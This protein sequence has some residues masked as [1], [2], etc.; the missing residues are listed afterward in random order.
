MTFTT[1]KTKIFAHRGFPVK[2]PEN[3]LPSFKLALESGADGIELDVILTK[4]KQPVVVHDFNLDR[5]SSIKGE[6]QSLTLAEIKAAD[7]GSWFSSEYAGVQIPTLQ[8]VFDLIGNQMLIN[9]ELKM[10][11]KDRSEHLAQIVV[12]LVHQNQLTDTVIYSSFNPYA[13]FHTKR[14]DHSASIGLLSTGDTIGRVVNFY[15]G[16]LRLHPNA[17]HLDHSHVTE[18]N[19]AKAHKKGIQIRSYTVNEVEEM[20]HF[21]AWGIDAIFTDNPQLALSVRDGE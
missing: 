8:E 10:P 18:K 16:K 19:I 6:V 15:Y 9:I 1:T 3:T 21:F 13:L 7:A 14:F 17:Y 2:A 4:D 5:T 20:K 12:D 11:I